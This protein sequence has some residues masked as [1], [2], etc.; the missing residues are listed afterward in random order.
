MCSAIAAAASLADTDVYKR[1]P[2]I[3]RYGGFIFC[4]FMNLKSLFKVGGFE[5]VCLFNESNQQSFGK[6]FLSLIHI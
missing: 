3:R 2:H 6:E 4:F 5:G 1:Q